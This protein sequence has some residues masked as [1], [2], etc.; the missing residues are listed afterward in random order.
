MPDATGP[1]K[2]IGEERNTPSPSTT[3]NG[4]DALR[5]ASLP[6]LLCRHA[7]CFGLA[8]DLLTRCVPSGRHQLTYLCD[9]AQEQRLR[10]LAERGDNCFDM[11]A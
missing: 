11:A 4:P 6:L 9:R 3:L 5:L 2:F 8:L 1:A 10:E 7:E